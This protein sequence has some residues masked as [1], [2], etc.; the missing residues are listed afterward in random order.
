VEKKPLDGHFDEGLKTIVTNTEQ[1]DL[2]KLAICKYLGLTDPK[3]PKRLYE[4]EAKQQMTNFDDSLLVEPQNFHEA[5]AQE[6][7]LQ[8]FRPRVESAPCLYRRWTFPPPPFAPPSASS[9]GTAG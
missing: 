8:I 1:I 6:L 7:I 3:L 9:S 5:L 4:Q 2:M